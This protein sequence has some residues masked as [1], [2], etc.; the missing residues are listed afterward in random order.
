MKEVAV[1]KEYT[2]IFNETFYY[3]EYV[4]LMHDETVIIYNFNSKKSFI[5]CQKGNKIKSKA[6]DTNQLLAILE[7]NKVNHGYA[8]ACLKKI[9]F[10]ENYKVIQVKDKWAHTFI[11]KY[12]NVGMEISLTDGELYH[13]VDF[14]QKV[15]PL[16][17]EVTIDKFS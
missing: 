3:E 1:K 6:V 4:H 10:N 9:G 14:Y 12:D 15:Q 5:V 16:K 11:S 2:N 13:S 17:E 8:K 7:L